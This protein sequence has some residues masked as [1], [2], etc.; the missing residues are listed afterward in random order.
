MKKIDK[1]SLANAFRLFETGDIDNIKTGTTKGL[2]Q[3]HQYWPIGRCLTDRNATKLF[4]ISQK[5]PNL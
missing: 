1:I 4:Q 2:Q 5:K 3:I